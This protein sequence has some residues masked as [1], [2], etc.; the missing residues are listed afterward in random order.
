MAKK[1]RKMRRSN[2][3]KTVKTTKK[4][5]I[6][7]RK[8]TKIKRKLKTFML[9]GELLELA[10]SIIDKKSSLNS[11][12]KAMH[13]YDINDQIN[14]EYLNKCKKIN[15]RDFK[16]LYTL[17]FENR[18][19]IR[20]KFKMNQKTLIQSSKIILF[21]LINFLIDIYQ[22]SSKK[23]EE[24]LDEFKLKHFE[25]FIIQI[26]EG[27]EELKYYYFINII[28]KWLK[29]A[30]QANKVK[31]YLS[32]FK[33]FFKVLSNLD[34]IEEVF[35]IIFRLNLMFF[36]RITDYSILKKVQYSINETIE[37][38]LQKL[39][40]IKDKIKEN[41]DKIKITDKTVLT[42]K[43]NNF[44][45]RPV[46][47]SFFTY[48]EVE[49]L[50]ILENIVNK[51]DMSYNYYKI[52]RLNYFN[53]DDSKRHAFISIVNI[54]LSSKV[55]KEYYHTVD[56]FQNYE[57]PFEKNNSK[58]FNYLWNKVIFIDLDN[59]TWCFTN[60]EGFGI[61]INRDKGKNTNGLGYGANVINI[62]HEFIKY[63]IKYLI[64][65]TNQI[66]AKSELYSD[67]GDRLEVLIFGQIVRN[68]T[69]GG[70]HFLFDINNWFLPLVQFLEGFN[71]NNTK[72]SAS[73]LKY[74]LINIKKNALVRALFEN[75]NY[76][77]VKDKME[78]QSISLRKN[79]KFSS[80]EL[81]MTGFR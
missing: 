40:L 48:S 64:N 42:L 49:D 12:K 78:S 75:I 17:S 7:K 73:S 37:E 16:Y 54:I 74:E 70:N 14:Y 33:N 3:K 47:Y 23:L 24:D 53:E 52:N 20:K 18:Q 26:S 71:K 22:P 55:I 58:I 69:Y 29:N 44:K 19:K 60:K 63:L 31:I 6:I 50:E 1:T 2:A 65:S 59:E 32:Y 39:Q 57:F 46:D 4:R 5:K 25:K 68:L 41:I 77:N 8:N 51:T 72:K 15:P 79:N 67:E 34:K 56:I 80:Q 45:F 62:V 9:P 10:K 27:T 35:Y 13:I 66:K 30:S 81:S 21:N 11:L 36:N 43:D 61:F 76:E 38:K 28:L